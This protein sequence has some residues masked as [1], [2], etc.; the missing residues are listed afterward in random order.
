MEMDSS[1]I[2]KIVELRDDAARLMVGDIPF[3]REGLVPVIFEPRPEALEIS[4]L[5]GLIDYL[6]SPVD[7]IPHDQVMLHIAGPKEVR[8]IS[9][10]NGAKRRRDNFATAKVDEK[11]RE[12]PFGQYM[13]VEIFVIQLRSMFQMTPDLERIIAYTSNLASGTAIVTQDDGISQTA[14]VKVGVSGA[15]KKN[16]TAPVIVH[17]KPFRTFREIDQIDS[18]FLFRI[19]TDEDGKNPACALFE[20]DGGKW[21]ND[22]VQEIRSWLEKNIEDISII[23]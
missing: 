15:L 10:I 5:T 23:A 14:T 21:R 18:E 12:Y 8:L 22:A 3:A 17:L 11:L 1:V 16:E 13:D 2:E 4:T 19:K 20:A 7:A 9:K 6:K